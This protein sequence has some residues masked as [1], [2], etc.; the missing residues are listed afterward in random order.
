MGKIIINIMVLMM[1]CLMAVAQDGELKLSAPQKVQTGQYFR[2]EVSANT[3]NVH[4]TKG[5]LSPL[6][7]VGQS[8]S[9]SSSSVN[10]RTTIKSSIIYTAYSNEPGKYKIEPFEA[11]INGQTV[12]SNALTIEVTGEAIEPQQP[13][14]TASQFHQPESVPEA[15]AFID[16]QLSKSEV[17]IGE[18]ITATMLLYTRRMPNVFTEFEE[19]KYNGFWS[20]ELEPTNNISFDRTI[21][22]KREYLVG[23]VQSK[24]LYAQKS[25]NLTIEPSKITM[26]SRMG[27]TF[28]ARSKA[29]TIKVKPLPADGKPADFGGA[30]GNFKITMTADRN[31]VKLDEPLTIKVNITGSGNFQLF[32][33]PKLDFPSAFEQ[34]SPKNESGENNKA[35]KTVVIARQPGEYVLPGIRLS[36][37]DPQSKTYKTVQ[38][39]DIK[40]TV[41]GE[42][43]AESAGQVALIGSEIEDLG[44]DIRFIKQDKINLVNGK[45][46]FFNSFNF[47]LIF[48]LLPI[49]SAGILI[50]RLQQIKNE[51]NVVGMKNRKAGKT[52]RKR[53]KKATQFI[54]ENKKDEFYVEVLNALWGYLG[55]KLSI[56]VSELNRDN[57][58]EKLTQKNIE[59]SITEKYIGALDTCEFEHYAP[60]SMSHSLQEVYD[61]AAEAIELMEGNIK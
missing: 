44:N 8:Q 2:I 36:Y 49:I 54:K 19:P 48:I 3:S 16:I 37:F 34:Y 18:S 46:Q 60:E 50:F 39:Q 59:P 35:F 42:R 6:N 53:L 61:M 30:V 5:S 43:S 45:K 56:P 57:V 52:S 17:Y 55:D 10:G 20:R 15:D 41:T 47:W 40:V 23:K 32:D 9:F 27:F 22:N 1:S 13:Q 58:Q 21:V 26:M 38:A 24:Q 11:E 33:I 51:A 14:N 28:E 7:V 4:I 25:G 12:K 29:K 31:E